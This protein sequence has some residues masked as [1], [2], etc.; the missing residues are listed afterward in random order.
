MDPIA[1]RMQDTGWSRETVLAEIEMMMDAK[2]R[3]ETGQLTVEDRRQIAECRRHWH[4]QGYRRS[5]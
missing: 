2:R 1:Q 4:P 3:F 5:R